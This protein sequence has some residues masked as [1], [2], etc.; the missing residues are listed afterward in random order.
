MLSL[1]TVNVFRWGKNKVEYKDKPQNI[2]PNE[3]D[4]LVELMELLEEID[5]NKAAARL[6]E[7][8]MVSNEGGRIYY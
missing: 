4:N 3:D 6:N 5:E 1:K 8:S 2:V 7:V